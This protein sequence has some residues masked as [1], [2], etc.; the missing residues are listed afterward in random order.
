MFLDKII[1]DG[2]SFVFRPYIID[3]VNMIVFVIIMILVVIFVNDRIK[4]MKMSRHIFERS[5]ML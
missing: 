1:F 3:M 4:E 5:L 2:C